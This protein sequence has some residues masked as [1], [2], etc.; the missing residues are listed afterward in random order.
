MIYFSNNKKGLFPKLVRFFTRSNI[1]HCG[2]IFFNL[3]Y[4]V[5]TVIESTTLVQ[6]VPFDRNYRNAN[7]EEYVVYEI[8]PKSKVDV[9]SLLIKTFNQYS[10]QSYGYFQLLWF[11]WRWFVGIFGFDI[12]QNKNWFTENVICSEVLFSFL[13]EHKIHPFNERLMKLNPD[14]VQADDLFKL[15]KSCPDIFRVVESKGIEV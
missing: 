11:V 3:G 14:T 6:I 4:G 5:D 1:S 12:S 8:L 9:S 10:G 2:I 7:N 13:K 15:V